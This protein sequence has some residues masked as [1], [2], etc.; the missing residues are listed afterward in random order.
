MAIKTFCGKNIVDVMDQ[1]RREVGNSGLLLESVHDKNGL[2]VT[3]DCPEI[4]DTLEGDRPIDLSNEELIDQNGPVEDAVLELSSQDFFQANASRRLE[5][6]KQCFSYHGFLEEE[7][8]FLN[9]EGLNL[10]KK[11]ETVLSQWLADNFSFKPLVCSEQK[12]IMLVGCPGVGKTT[13]MARLAVKAIAEGESPVLVT[14]DVEKAGGVDQV[15]LFAEALQIPFFSCYTPQELEAQLKSLD[16]RHL[17]LIDTP[18][19]NPR[20]SEEV[21]WMV[22]M[23]LT[24]RVSP[25]YV[26]S[27]GENPIM[28]ED[29]SRQFFKLGARRMLI[30]RVDM[31]DRLGGVL[32]TALQTKM[33]LAG[34]SRSPYVAKSFFK[35]TPSALARQMLYVSDVLENSY[36]SE[37]FFE[38]SAA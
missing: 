5:K 8:L 23:V 15:R 18:G 6:L 9:E 12:R 1:I 22:E 38:E 32:R 4:E 28:T 30:T 33:A 2:I 35:A 11:E 10:G 31:F 17:V 29:F 13:M 27:A 37:D 3:V 36:I 34:W 26:L 24:A 7:S 25:I 16:Q 21:R 14:T 20:E 19:I